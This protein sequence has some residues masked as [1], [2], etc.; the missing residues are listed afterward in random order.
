MVRPSVAGDESA[1]DRFAQPEAG[2][3]SWGR[4]PSE[5]PECGA[6]AP[7]PARLR[8]LVLDW[9]PREPLAL[10]D[11]TWPVG[12]YEPLV[13]RE[14]AE[15]LRERFAGFEVVPVEVRDAPGA[16][17]EE[18]RDLVELT[19]VRTCTPEPERSTLRR[20][21][22]PCPAC[23]SHILFWGES[24]TL[25]VVMRSRHGLTVIEGV[26]YWAAGSWDPDL[27][28]LARTRHPREDGRGL[29]VERAEL[30]DEGLF[31]IEGDNKA[32][33]CTDGMKRFVEGR[34]LTNV[35]FLRGGDV[36]ARER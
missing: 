4:A 6:P 20:V 35:G 12:T 1:G 29:F 32:V 14:L 23:G 2:P 9:P 24:G 8:P 18:A 3:G 21:R 22:P 33:M 15:E 27:E 16:L 30:G 25:G 31:L 7:R 5:C 11:F 17:V 13:R 26:E 19:I 36:L 28:A 34:G 10:G